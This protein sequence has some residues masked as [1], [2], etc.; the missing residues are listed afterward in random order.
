[1]C[2]LLSRVSSSLVS[3]RL[4]LFVF[5]YLVKKKNYL[6]TLTQNPNFTTAYVCPSIGYY[7]TNEYG[8][9]RC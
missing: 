9:S 6:F 1:M 2:R 8:S 4:M 7:G 5:D 3:D